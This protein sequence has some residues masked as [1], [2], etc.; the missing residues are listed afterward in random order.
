MRRYADLY[1]ALSDETRLGALALILKHGELCVCYVEAVLE[2]TQSKASRHLRYLKNVGILDDR[3]EGT[4]VHYRLSRSPTPEAALVVK[5]NRKLLLALVEKD[6]EVKLETWLR[7]KDR[8]KTCSGIAR[9][10]C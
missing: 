7:S 4:W 9:K 5:N 10:A 2:I 8:C 1:K 3:R 6:L